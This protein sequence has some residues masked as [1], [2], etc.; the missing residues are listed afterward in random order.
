MAMMFTH[1]R[2]VYFVSKTPLEQ[3]GDHWVRYGAGTRMGACDVLEL[4][5]ADAYDGEGRPLVQP[6]AVREMLR[7]S[8]LWEV[9]KVLLSI[10]WNGEVFE[11][12]NV[13]RG[14]EPY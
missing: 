7:G 11:M 12:L 4:L 6:R 10:C 3:V 1:G 13:R 9:A 2:R 5:Q 14:G 8:L